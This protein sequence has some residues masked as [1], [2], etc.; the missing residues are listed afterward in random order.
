[1]TPPK[2]KQGKKWRPRDGE[3]CWIVGIDEVTRWLF[4]SKQRYS[5]KMLRLGAIYRIECEAKAARKRAL[6]ALKNEGE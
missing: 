1:M 5:A 2:K 6:K 3:L 4:Y